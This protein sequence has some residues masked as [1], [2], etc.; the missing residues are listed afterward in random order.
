MLPML[1]VPYNL[2]SFF[3]RW[4]VKVGLRFAQCNRSW[5]AIYNSDD[6]NLAVSWLHFQ[7]VFTVQYP[8]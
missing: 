6:Y 1:P 4:G 2:M 8:V 3:I 5:V 7:D